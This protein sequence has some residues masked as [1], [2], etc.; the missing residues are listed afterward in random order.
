MSGW[1]SG[2]RRQT[3]GFALPVKQECERARRVMF[4]APAALLALVALAALVRVRSLDAELGVGKAINIFMRYGY[5]SIC[6]RVVPRNDTDSWVFREPT[7]GV[8]QNIERYT[9]P[10]PSRDARALFHGDF[11][12]EFCDNI[13]QLLQAYFRDFSFERHD[14]IGYRQGSGPFFQPGTEVAEWSER[15]IVY[16]FTDRGI[17]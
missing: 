10:R 12:M 17:P 13:K 11:H 3:L 2:L 9:T 8:F 1:P 5:L 15:A 7:V 14:V 4:R 6:M 16:D